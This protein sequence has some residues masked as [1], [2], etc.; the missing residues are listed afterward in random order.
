MRMALETL[1]ALML[2]L[3][4]Y[5]AL[6]TIEGIDAPAPKKLIELLPNQAAHF[7]V[8][9]QGFKKTFTRKNDDWLEGGDLGVKVF[10]LLKELSTLD[11]LPLLE[12]EQVV[13]GFIRWDGPFARTIELGR[14][15][16]GGNVALKI[17]GQWFLGDGEIVDRLL[18]LKQVSP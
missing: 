12:D 5:V 4:A 2:G 14:P 7:E 8:Q 6:P 11:E 15:L 16:L 3:I 1:V 9:W 13:K 18:D 10:G 17:N